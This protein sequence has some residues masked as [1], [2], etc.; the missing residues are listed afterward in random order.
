MVQPSGQPTGEPSEQPTGQ[1]TGQPTRDPT[2]QPSEQPSGQPSALP[3][4]PSGQPLRKWRL[5]T[6]FL[7]SSISLKNAAV[8]PIQQF[9]LKIQMG[10]LQRKMLF[11][12]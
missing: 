7:D 11:L 10:H 1:P 6:V 4:Q 3:T 12:I 8:L 5:I 9:L 2:G